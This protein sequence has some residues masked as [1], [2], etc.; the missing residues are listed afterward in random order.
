MKR[1][2][3]LPDDVLL[4]IFDFYMTINPSL[5]GGK[6]GIEVWQSL[7]HVCRR[8]RTLVLG[9]PRHL[10]LQLCCTPKTPA[11]DTL[12][13][14]PV[15]PL[16]VKGDMTLSGTDNIVAA[17]EQSNRVCEVFLRGLVG[18]QLENVLAAMQ[19]S[20]P[21]LTDL[22]LYSNGETLPAIPD[23]FLGGS[24]PR[25][26][27][28]SSTGI[29]FP[30]LPKLLLSANHL[31]YLEL[32]NIPHSGYISPEAMAALLSVLPGLRRL[33]LQFQS[34]QSHPDW[35][36]RG[37]PPPK[38]SIL[39]ALDEF[40]F[41]GVTEYLEGL[42]TRIDTP[43]LKRLFITF[44]NQIDF[45]TLRLAQFINRTPTFRA[46]DEAHVQFD[47]RIASV[48]LR[49][50]TSNFIFG[51]LEISISCEEPDWQLSSI[52]QVCNSSLRHLST[53]EDLYIDRRY[54]PLIWKNDAIEDVLWLQLL[55][56]FPAV[57]NLY[58][59]KEFA[60][61]IVAA[62]R[63]LVGGRIIEVLP[64]LQNIRA[65]GLEPSGRLQENIG[66]LVAAR[67]LSDHPIAIS[68][69]EKG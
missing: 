1:I 62:L 53:V 18:W 68:V 51:Q 27:I 54:V 57:K 6:T 25:L 5:F 10:N 64:S 69:W 58:L 61:G 22:R 15:L 43:Q 35:E 55:L 31:L 20:F 26:R 45:D 44:F 7:V 66:Q 2:D 40:H 65:E 28:F 33:S 23:S 3:V 12:D 42:V 9:S 50:R 19:V 48:K 13:V 52:E 32:V 24:A 34:P 47:G 29:P 38:R 21:E 67:Q 46:L 36:S 56:A 14:W 37:P 8:W 30:G 39:P 17:L 4:G 41:K 49:Y 59:S 11:K 16:I 63:G 60:P